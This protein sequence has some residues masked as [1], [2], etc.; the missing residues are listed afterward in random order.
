MLFV[1][2]VQTYIDNNSIIVIKLYILKSKSKLIVTKYMIILQE[3]QIYV[4]NNSIIVI[5]LYVLKRTYP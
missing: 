4:D 3:I 5:K 2:E 1:Q